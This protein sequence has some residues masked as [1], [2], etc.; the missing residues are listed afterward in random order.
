[1][2]CAVCSSVSGSV[3]RRG[4]GIGSCHGHV[5]AWGSWG[6]AIGVSDVDSHCSSWQL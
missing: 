5:F 6:A 4:S 3:C 1:M 2:V